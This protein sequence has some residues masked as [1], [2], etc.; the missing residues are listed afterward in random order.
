MAYPTV[1]QYNLS[2]GIGQMFVYAQATVPFFADL[3]FGVI[4]IIV[5]FSIY[6]GQEVKKGRGDFPVALAVGTT[7]TLVLAVIMGMLSNFIPFRTMG[8][9]LSI[10]IIS[11][12]WIFFS[13]P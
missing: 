7:S 3:L 11:Y 4:L 10:T 1:D 6:F 8:I 12:F 2:S 13:E 9:L 5:T